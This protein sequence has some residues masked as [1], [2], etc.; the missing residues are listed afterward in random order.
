MVTSITHVGCEDKGRPDEDINPAEAKD[1]EHIVGRVFNF[2]SKL[3]YSSRE[4]MS[5]KERIRLN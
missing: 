1:S 5:D 4:G 2:I 3:L